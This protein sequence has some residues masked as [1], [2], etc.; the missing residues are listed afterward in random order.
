MDC[1]Q[2]RFWGRFKKP[3]SSRWSAFNSLTLREVSRLVERPY[4]SLAFLFRDEACDDWKNGIKGRV[5]LNIKTKGK[6][7][8]YLLELSED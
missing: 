2:R 3:F 8:D 7:V 5:R 4:N 1:R 6:G